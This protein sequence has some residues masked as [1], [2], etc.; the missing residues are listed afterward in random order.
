MLDCSPY[1][2]VTVLVCGSLAGCLLAEPAI[3][4]EPLHARIDKLVNAQAGTAVGRTATD[5]EFLRRVYLD[6]AGRIPSRSEAVAFLANE[7]PAKRE[8][9]IDQ[10][11]NSKE[12]PRRMA[13]L[14]H[15]MLMERMGD[16]EEWDKYLRSCFAANKPWDQIARQI[17]NPN[18]ED[19]ATRG[20]AFF[21]TKRLEKYG[22][23]PVDYPGLVRDVGRM[24]LGVDVQ[25]AQCHDHLFVD[26]Y[27]QVDYQGLFAFVGQTMIRTDLK[28]P[29]V[30]EKL[31]AKPVEFKSVF[32]MED[33]LTGPRLPFGSEIEVPVF[34]KGE[35]YEL[36]PDRKTRFPGRPKFSPLQMLSQQLPEHPL[37][38]KNI[39]N[40]LWW[41]MLGR[42][43]VFPLDL[44]HSDN[45]ASHPELLALLGD[46][47]AAHE[48]DLKWLIRELV[49][50]ETYQRASLFPEPGNDEIAESTYQIAL[51]KALSAE[52]LL[53]SMLQ[54]VGNGKVVLFDQQDEK[55]SELRE[56]FA[57]AFANPPREPEIGHQPSVKAALFLLNDDVLLGW[58]EPKDGNLVERL[59]N[60]NDP[61]QVAEE[62]YLSV[63]SRR[64]NAEE[65]EEV[66][67]YLASQT[68]AHNRSEEDVR[69]T[70]C[71][72]LAWALLASAEF[73]VNH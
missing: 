41:A 23:N 65:V 56:R 28:F 58:L 32:M 60:S 46:E 4:A 22:Q 26:D 5:A 11:L 16:H 50:T 8:Q 25:C 42:G 48:Y 44:H 52:Q 3:A 64:P 2:L 33:R 9:V 13:Q 27:K 43:L 10:L 1:R 14:F 62:L 72:D 12:Y 70:A 51:E 17:A 63:L 39:A 40:R 66:S 73:G 61:S 15:V 34:A 53:D 45:P 54:A 67:S 36:P 68:A 21:I 57:K 24:F 55:L 69:A 20:S 7:A 47:L 37:F 6:L 49:L 31:V 18:A 30:A 35:E 29:A 38:R 71:G 59:V 19:E